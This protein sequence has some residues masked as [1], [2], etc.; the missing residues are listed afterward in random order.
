MA[1]I[2][3]DL[4]LVRACHD[5]VIVESNGDTSGMS[6]ERY[7]EWKAGIERVS[8]PLIA[9]EWEWSGV[10]C[11]TW[12]G[13]RCECDGGTHNT[14]GWFDSFPCEWCGYE[15]EGRRFNVAI[16]RRVMSDEATEAERHYDEVWAG[17]N[18]RI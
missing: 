7:L 2:V 12:V 6:D 8:A 15:E 14:D 4:A 17:A 11:D 1:N 13:E 10:Q 3:Y 18:G 5:C 9:D 16:M